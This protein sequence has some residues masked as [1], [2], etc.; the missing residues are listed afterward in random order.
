ML[1][2]FTVN[3][4]LIASAVIPALGLL[5]LV[6]RLDKTE[7]EPWPLL[8]RLLALGAASGVLAFLTETAGIWLL[9]SFVENRFLYHM[10]LYYLVVAASE[11]GF[12][13]LMLRLSTWNS[14]SFDYRFDGV[15]YAV[16][17]SLGFAILENI[18]YVFSYGLA[19]ALVRAVTAVPGHACFGVFMGV[20]YGVAKQF[21]VRGYAARSR[22]YRL[23]ALVMPLLLH[24]TYD[25]IA[26]TGGR[27]AL[28]VFAAFVLLLFG[29]AWHSLHRSSREDTYIGNRWGY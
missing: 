3:R 27:V 12:K 26:S 15:V 8:L 9:D 29:A 5:A 28:A 14:P 10:L 11:E 2:Y 25:L 23:L 7:K 6:Y 18:G 17:V 22:A 21:E 20:W 13:Y 24:G 19:T 1:L 4:I 16:F